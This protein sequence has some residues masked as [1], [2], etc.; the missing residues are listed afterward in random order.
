MKNNIYNVGLSSANISKKELCEKIKK[1]VP[2]FVFI[3]SKIGKDP[4]KRDYIVSNSKLES[5]GWKSRYS[6]ESGIKELVK[7]YK[8]LKEE[9]NNAHLYGRG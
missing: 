6:L 7:I 4:D 1:I 9:Y 5:T 8:S 2:K 3:D